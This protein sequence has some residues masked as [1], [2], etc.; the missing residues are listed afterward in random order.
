MRGKLF[1]N[2]N[3][4]NRF[5]QIGLYFCWRSPPSTVP[6]TACKKTGKQLSG[7]GLIFEVKH[8]D[9]FDY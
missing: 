6:T 8:E 5:L 1:V 4:H 3:I 7:F 9:K 2:Q